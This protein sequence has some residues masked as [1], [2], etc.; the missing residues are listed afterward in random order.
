M[1]KT[2]TVVFEGTVGDDVWKEADCR[3]LGYVERDPRTE[4]NIFD[5]PHFSS[6]RGGK[7]GGYVYRIKVLHSVPNVFGSRL[8]TAARFEIAGR[9]QYGITF[10]CTD[11]R[12]DAWV[13]EPLEPGKQV[14]TVPRKKQ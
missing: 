10:Y 1:G 4:A 5:A 8:G 12:S 7:Y 2:D 14:I 3:G 13:V 9:G 6:T 11:N